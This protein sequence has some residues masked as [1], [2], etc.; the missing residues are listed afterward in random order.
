M[1]YASLFANNIDPGSTDDVKSIP[2]TV[3]L[4]RRIPAHLT[5]EVSSDMLITEMM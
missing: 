4:S 3:D 1:K 2:D 5:E